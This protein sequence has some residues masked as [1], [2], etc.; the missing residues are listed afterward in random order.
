M[1]TTFTLSRD[2]IITLALRKL[3]VLD[4]EGVASAAQLTNHSLVLNMML[5]AWQSK[6]MKLWTVKE[7]SLPLVANTNV[8]TIGPAGTVVQ[9]KPLKLIQA[10]L[11]NESVSPNVDLP[12][13][14]ISRQE[15]NILSAKNSQGIANSVFLTPN[16]TDAT[17]KVWLSP[18]TNTATNYK[19]WIVVQE[20]ISDVNSNV[21]T[22][23]PNEWMQSLV[24]NMAAEL[25]MDYGIPDQRMQLIAMQAAKY[26]EEM[27]DWDVECNSTF[28]QPDM[29]AQNQRGTV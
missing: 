23:F 11:R 2:D 1:S 15:Y 10:W 17:L 13:N 6:G 27:E 5:K 25:A 12:M 14:I 18:D 4:I 7:Y 26:K 21:A 28:F 16:S 3:G 22:D 8:Y 29:R 20:A 24:W 19:L 9:N